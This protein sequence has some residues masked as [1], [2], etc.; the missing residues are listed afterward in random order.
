MLQP[1]G[2]IVAVG[3]VGFAGG[4]ALARYNPN[5]SLDMS[6]SGD[7]MR[8]TDFGGSDDGAREW[9]SKRTARSSRSEAG[10]TTTSCSPATTPTGRSTRASPGT[11]GRP[12]TGGA[13][14][15]RGG[16]RSR[17]RQDRRG[18]AW[19]PP[20]SRLRARP[21]QPNG[22]LD[23]S[24]S[25]DGKQTTDFGG[26]DNGARGVAIQTDGKIVVVGRSDPGGVF[27]LA[28]Y[29]PNGS[30]DTSFSGDGS[31]PPTSGAPTGR[32]G[33][34]S[35]ATARSSRSGAAAPSLTTSRSP[36]TT[37]TARSTRAF[38]ATEADHRLRG[39]RRRGEGGGAQ[40]TA[41]SSR[42]AAVA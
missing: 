29:N 9:R 23:T 35:R 36:A 40:R 28:R 10:A 1:N 32:Q 4:F 22:S 42:S 34:R 37:P 31:R 8:I 5:G 27:A 13:S 33:W 6:F 38:P 3:A 30:L 7:G 19:R 18:R 12:S 16:W 17:G 15:G 24:F 2:K 39:L 26:V 41:R 25:G 14:T 21:L 11:A 20:P